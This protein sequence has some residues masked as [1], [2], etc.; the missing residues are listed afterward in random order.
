[1]ILVSRV[2]QNH[3]DI[4]LE[5]ALADVFWG[6]WDIIMVVAVGSGGNGHGGTSG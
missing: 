2:Q 5:R 6:I 4:P 3:K 1:M